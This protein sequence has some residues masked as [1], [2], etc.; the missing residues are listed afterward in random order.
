MIALEFAKLG[1]KV[2]C[3]CGGHR[4]HVFQVIVCDV[5]TAGAEQ[6]ARLARE[7]AHDKSAAHV[8]TVDICDRHAVYKCVPHTRVHTKH[9]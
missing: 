8:Y 3:T 6:T 1:A 9:V 7:C 2:W 5:N 4:G